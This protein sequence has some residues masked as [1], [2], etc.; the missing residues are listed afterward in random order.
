MPKIMNE[1][2]EWDN[3]VDTDTVEGPIERVMRVEI[4]E[5]FKHLEIG[6]APGPFEAYAKMIVANGDAEIRVLMEPY[7]RILDGKGMPAD[8][9]MSTAILV[10]KGKGDIIDCGVYCGIKQIE[11]ITKVV[12]KAL[13]KEIDKS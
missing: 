6:K 2:N 10:S 13:E 4:M 9:A 1:E 3:T 8:W 12:E 11:H 7:Q 5:A